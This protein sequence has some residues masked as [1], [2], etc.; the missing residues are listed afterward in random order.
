MIC[1][2][3]VEDCNWPHCWYYPYE[4][5]WLELFRSK[6]YLNSNKLKIFIGY[7]IN[8]EHILLKCGSNNSWNQECYI[9]KKKKKNLNLTCPIYF[10]NFPLLFHIYS[11]YDNLLKFYIINAKPVR[12]T[13]LKAKYTLN[14]T[15]KINLPEDGHFWTW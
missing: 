6:R 8:L 5:S 11:Y 2:K 1:M 10:Q 13:N 4:W 12:F 15:P 7:W 3:P 9:S 14:P